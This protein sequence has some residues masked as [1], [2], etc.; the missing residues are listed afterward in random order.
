MLEPCE[1]KISR[2]VLRGEGSRKAAVLPGG[3][4]YAFPMS[5]RTVAGKSINTMK[6]ENSN[7][8]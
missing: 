5:Y 1:V 7:F 2:R 3:P 8:F 6:I 4:H